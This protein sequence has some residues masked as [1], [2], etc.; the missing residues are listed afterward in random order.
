MQSYHCYLMNYK[1]IIS[2][3]Q[4]SETNKQTN[5]TK[6]RIKYKADYLDIGF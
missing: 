3:D 2:M 5:K 4:E 6:D 1:I